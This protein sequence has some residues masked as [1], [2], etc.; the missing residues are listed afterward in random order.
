MYVAFCTSYKIII[1]GET[2]RVMAGNV[3]ARG[4]GALTFF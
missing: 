3:R 4:G 1:S 2:G